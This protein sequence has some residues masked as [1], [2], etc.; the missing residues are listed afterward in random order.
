MIFIP[1]VLKNLYLPHLFI[2]C[3]QE[4]HNEGQAGQRGAAPLR[5]VGMHNLELAEA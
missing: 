5:T 4:E 2:D 3:Y 1:Y